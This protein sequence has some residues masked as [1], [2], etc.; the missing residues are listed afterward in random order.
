MKCLRESGLNFWLLASFH[1]FPKVWRRKCSRWWEETQRGDQS[2]PHSG[3][4][5]CFPPFFCRFCSHPW[6]NLRLQITWWNFS[7]IEHAFVFLRS[8]LLVFEVRLQNIFSPSGC[9]EKTPLCEGQ[10]GRALPPRLLADAL[11]RRL[12]PAGVSAGRWKSRASTLWH[13]RNTTPSAT[14]G[15]L[16]GCCWNGTFKHAD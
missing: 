13:H 5:W 10:R 11:K 3:H 15:S 2:V 8:S 9:G 16:T 4:C 12:K 1:M 6:G 7:K 14:Q